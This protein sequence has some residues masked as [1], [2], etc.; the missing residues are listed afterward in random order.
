MNLAV[1]IIKTALFA[2]TFYSSVY[3]LM[4]PTTDKVVYDKVHKVC[5]CVYIYDK[6]DD[7]KT[8][9]CSTLVLQATQW[10]PALIQR[11]QAKYSSSDTWPCSMVPYWRKYKQAV[12][13]CSSCQSLLLH[14]CY[15]EV[16]KYNTCIISTWLKKKLVDNFTVQN[17][18]G[19]RGKYQTAIA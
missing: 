18:E 4:P 11:T 2:L 9:F 7:H 17:G 10:Y 6:V 5:V 1:T 19:M 15:D 16:P 12:E 13:L 8:V 14:T 3:M